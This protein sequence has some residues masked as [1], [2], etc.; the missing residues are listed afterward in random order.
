MSVTTNQ[1]PKYFRYNLLGTTTVEGVEYLDVLATRLDYILEQVT[2]SITHVV[3]DGVPL[4]TVSNNYYGTTS[5]WWLIMEYN[6]LSHVLDLEGGQELKIPDL[7]N[8][9]FDLPEKDIT[10]QTVVI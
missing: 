1:D 4:T 6:G 7:N 5:L 10:G 2:R 8:V 3:V 9:N